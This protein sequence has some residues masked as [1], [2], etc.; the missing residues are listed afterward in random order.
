MT[1][2]GGGQQQRLT[3]L[4]ALR[5]F[6]ILG[7][8]FTHAASLAGLRGT[9]RNL[10]NSA[11]NGVL[12]FFVI[13]ACT[14]FL[15]IS[16][17][18]TRERRPWGNFYIKRF[19]RLFPVYW[20]GIIL[21]TAV[22]GLA[23]RGWKPGPEIWHYPFHATLTNLLLPTVMSS[24]VPGGWSISCEALFYL[25][26]P[27]WFLLAR[28]WRS[29]LLLALGGFIVGPMVVKLLSHVL[30]PL[31]HT[32]P[33]AELGTYW[34]RS[35]PAQ[36][37]VFF[38]GM[39]LYFL[40]VEQPLF[41]RLLRRPGPNLLLLAAALALL[42]FESFRA[43]PLLQRQYV[44]GLGFLAIALALSQIPWRLAVNGVTEWIGRV[45]YSAYLSHFL[46]LK[47][48]SL[49]FPNPGWTAAA[50]TLFLTTVS[51]PPTLLLSW[52]GFRWVEQPTTR[53]AKR[54]VKGRETR[55]APS[56][57]PA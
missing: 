54:L 41:V 34:Y 48:L 3:Y 17:A 56:L 29:A 36:L 26:V 35:L 55:A 47:Q 25:T 21:Y 16:K 43:V 40:M 44:F 24:V 42:L 30:N 57:S 45:S 19:L 15:T 20:L 7:V 46:V 11:G 2:L 10:S 50:Y 51:L 37:G 18:V 9:L 5:G 12:L 39:A 53:I 27:L 31:F 23:S 33:A 28:G 32:V 22:Y 1:D 8:I 38:C 6:A 13:S 49:A 14:I 4:D 52:I